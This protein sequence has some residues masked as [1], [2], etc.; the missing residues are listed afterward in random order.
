[1]KHYLTLASRYLSAHRKK[2]RLSIISI[3]ISVAL[4]TGIFS[5]GDVLMRFEKLQVIHE[6]GNYHIALVDLSP[7]EIST[8]RNR[9]DVRNSGSWKDLGKGMIN[10]TGC[11][12]G[13][14]DEAFAGNLNIKVIQGKYPS[15]KNEIM[16]EKW[17]TAIRFVFHLQV[18]L[19]GNLW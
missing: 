19:K 5:M 2:T 3:A 10:G 6:Y 8:I 15:G 13:A 18:I 12:L 1:M 9:I 11:R 17:A 4:I 7:V 16:L 14:L